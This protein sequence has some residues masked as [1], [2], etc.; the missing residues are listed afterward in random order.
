MKPEP[1]LMLDHFHSRCH[2]YI[3]DVIYVKVDGHCGYRSTLN[4]FGM[5][6]DSWPLGT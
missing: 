2:P 6:E 4:Y 5:G 3:M 1:R